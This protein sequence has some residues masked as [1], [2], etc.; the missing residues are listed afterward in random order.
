MHRQPC[1][2]VYTDYRPTPL[3]HFIYSAG[4][5]GLYEVVDMK[6]VFRDDQFSKAM[7]FLANETSQPFG[8]E[9]RRIQDSG[10]NTSV[11]KIIRTIKER[12]ML[13]CIIFSFSR[14][15]CEA[16]ASTLKDVDFNDGT[17]FFKLYI[18]LY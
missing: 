5:D 14:K 9:K 8:K 15:E 10:G 7:S 4:S 13:P 18:F 3:Q 17:V 11:I 1:H 16:Y 6:G 2:V 12:D